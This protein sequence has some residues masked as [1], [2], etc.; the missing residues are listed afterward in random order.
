MLSRLFVLLSCSLF[1]WPAS[2]GWEKVVTCNDD[3]AVIDVNT[4]E[5]R[6]LQLVIRD[7]QIIQH[8]NELDLW[9]SKWG[10]REIIMK[11]FAGYLNFAKGGVSSTGGVFYPHDFTGLL[12]SSSKNG[13][14]SFYH[15]VYIHNETVTVRKFRHTRW[16]HCEPFPYEGY[17][18][19]GQH[20]HFIQEYKIHDCHRV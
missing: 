5:R 8:F 13:Y 4:D 2:A 15:A 7:P 6:F 1:A 10:D 20:L 17:C 11:G 9:E 14:G 3:R 19:S 18:K 12:H 16:S